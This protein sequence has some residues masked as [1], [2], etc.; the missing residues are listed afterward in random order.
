MLFFSSSS[1]TFDTV[2][3][4]RQANVTLVDCREE[5]II[6]RLGVKCRWPS[7]SESRLPSNPLFDLTQTKADATISADVQKGNG[8]ELRCENVRFPTPVVSICVGNINK[9]GGSRST[10]SSGPVQ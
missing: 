7:R 2:Y 3:I 8:T 5:H 4:V 9:N 1:Q 10:R 6:R